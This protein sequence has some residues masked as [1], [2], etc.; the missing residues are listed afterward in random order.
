MTRLEEQTATLLV[1]VKVGKIKNT[2]SLEVTL[3]SVPIRAGQPGWNSVEWVRE[4]LETIQ[5]NKKAMG[6][7]ILDWTAVRDNA[8]NYVQR[9]ISDH[10]FDGQA[11]GLFDM[12]MAATFDLLL[13]EETIR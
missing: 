2:S 4:A 13:G 1:R 7:S 6:T 10:R 3:R 11:P 12:S 5:N 8:M 9:K